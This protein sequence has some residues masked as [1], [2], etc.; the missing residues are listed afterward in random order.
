MTIIATDTARLSN[1]VKHELWPETGYCRK[2]LTV[3]EA[4]AKTYV[5]GT[6]LGFDGTDYKISVETAVDGSEVPAAVVMADYSVAAT[7]DTQVLCLVKGPAEVS[8]D[9]LALDASFDDDTKKAAAYAALEA[10][11][12]NI[13]TT[14]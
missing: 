6:V 8:Q 5:V 2:M 14:N 12:I 10:L 7:T 3:N 9:A 13:L 1:L 11:G 4:A